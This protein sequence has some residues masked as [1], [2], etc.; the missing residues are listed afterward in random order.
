[1]SKPPLAPEQPEIDAVATPLTPGLI[2]LLAISVGVVVAN[3][4]YVQPLMGVIARG[5]GV[6]DEVIGYAITL[7]QAGLALG[8]LTILPL[9]DI[10]DRRRLITWSCAG[11]A[12]SLVIMTLAPNAAVFLAANFLLG[13]TSIATHLQLSYAAHLAAPEKR[14]HAVGVVLSGLLIG[15]IVARTVSG[16]GGAWYGWRFVLLSASVVTF[17][18]AVVVRLK[19]PR[20]DESHA[21]GYGELLGSMPHLITSQPVLR[22]S[23]VYGAL[24]FAVFNAV[25]ATLTFYLESPAFG[26]NSSSIGLFGLVAVSGAVVANLSGRLTTRIRPV[27]IIVGALVV[28]VLAFAV[29]FGWGGTITGL[30]IGMIMMDMGVQATHVGNQ[31]RVHALNPLMRNRLH[32]IYMV[33]YFIG[34]AAGSAIGTWSYAGWGWAGLCFAC[35]LLCAIAFLYWLIKQS[36]AKRKSGRLTG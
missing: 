7:C 18:L 27:S 24:T 29:M 13:F 34:G 5:F 17:A 28:M 23:C 16:F 2:L 6:R 4:Y 31:T 20:D 11:S 35:S 30:V 25:W 1:M 14:G 36:I 26:M 33:T 22:A 3:L 12:A 32:T 8:T 9:G 19:L 15:I 21:I 10:S